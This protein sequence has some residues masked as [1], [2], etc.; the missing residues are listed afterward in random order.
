MV[1]QCVANDCNG[2]SQEE[3]IQNAKKEALWLAKNEQIR[4][5]N[6]D[7]EY[8][9]YAYKHPVETSA[10]I[11]TSMITLGLS[12]PVSIGG[13]INGLSALG[14]K[15]ASICLANVYCSAIIGAGGIGAGTSRALYDDINVS[16]DKINY[17][18]NTPGKSEGFSAL[19]YTAESLTIEL[20]NLGRTVQ[21][22][23]FSKITEFG[24]RYG[25]ALEVSIGGVIGRI[26][27]V[28][29]IDNGTNV[30]RFL[31]AWVEIFK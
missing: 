28:W 3:I 1:T 4:C 18:I 10:F 17:L 20:E 6:G 24:P 11:I 14:W 2:E 27:T 30:L 23:D 7:T 12:D 15:A 29:Q 13:M 8:C 21:Q 22:S 26:N 5:E 9:S 25:K 16:K 19:G 31:T